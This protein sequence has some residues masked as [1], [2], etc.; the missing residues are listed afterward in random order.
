M[1]NATKI[2]QIFSYD[3][4]LWLIYIQLGNIR[5]NIR[6]ICIFICYDGQFNS[7]LLSRFSYRVRVTP[8]IKKKE[9]RKKKENMWNWKKKKKKRVLIHWYIYNAWRVNDLFTK[10]NNYEVKTAL[11]LLR[12]RLCPLSRT[13]TNI[14]CLY[15]V[16]CD[17]IF[18]IHKV[19]GILNAWKKHKWKG[20]KRH[21][22]RTESHSQL[23]LDLS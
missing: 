2:L 14:I 6:D 17:K 15:I 3:W 10:F 20:N 21:I 8:Q 22:A 18:R 13:S 7:L 12:S 11:T 16:K 5:S 9:K 19:N 23:R 4:K 1:H